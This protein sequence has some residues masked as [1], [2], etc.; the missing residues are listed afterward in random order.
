MMVTDGSLLLFDPYGVGDD[1]FRWHSH[2]FHEEGTIATH[3][4]LKSHKT[5]HADGF[6]AIS[7]T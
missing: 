2:R 1:L 5:F 7:R 4:Y 6:N 3:L